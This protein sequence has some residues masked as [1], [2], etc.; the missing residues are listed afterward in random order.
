V[1]QVNGV[2]VGGSLVIVA[3]CVDMG[4]GRI[5]EDKTGIGVGKGG[6][7]VEQAVMNARS[8]TRIAVRFVA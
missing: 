2:G 1:R 8:E 6:L 7:E 4:M 3:V 5:V